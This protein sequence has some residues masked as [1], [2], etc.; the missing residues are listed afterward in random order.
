MSRFHSFN[1]NSMVALATML[2][3]SAVRLSESYPILMEI[4]HND[5]QVGLASKIHMLFVQEEGLIPWIGIWLVIHNETPPSLGCSSP[6]RCYL[7]LVPVT[8]MLGTLNFPD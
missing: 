7:L 2:L 1:C 3:I 6:S 5:R 4:D 8:N